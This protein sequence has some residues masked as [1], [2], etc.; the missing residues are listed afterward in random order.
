M[1]L[2]YNE[3]PAEEVRLNLEN[4]IN[5]S[6]NLISTSSFLTC[7][8]TSHQKSTNDSTVTLLFLLLRI[9]RKYYPVSICQRQECDKKLERKKVIH[10]TFSLQL[11]LSK[12][13]MHWQVFVWFVSVRERLNIVKE[14]AITLKEQCQSVPNLAHIHLIFSWVYKQGLFLHWTCG[15]CLL[16]SEGI[17]FEFLSND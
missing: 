7:T 15:Y 6:I 3:I 11:C 1:Q 17:W 4:I 9:K 12:M 16:N 5:K 10:M 13:Q 8:M 14:K 2:D